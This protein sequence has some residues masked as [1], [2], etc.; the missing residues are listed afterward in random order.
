MKLLIGIRFYVKSL[1]HP[2]FLRLSLGFIC[3]FWMFLLLFF[4]SIGI[5][6]VHAQEVTWA[7]SAGGSFS[8]KGNDI[9]VDGYGNIYVVGNF[10]DTALF[11]AGTLYSVVLV[12]AGSSD[13]FLAKYAPDSTLL[14]AQ[15]AGGLGFDI[16]VGIAV[17]TSVNVVITGF[18]GG[19]AIFGQGQPGM[20][21]LTGAGSSDIFIA[22]YAGDGT[23][24]WAESAGGSED[25]YGEDIDIDLNNDIIVTGSFSNIA[26]FGSGQVGAISLSSKGYKNIF[27]AKY[28]SD[29]TLLWAIK[30]GGANF[31]YGYGVASDMDNHVFITG[32]FSAIA[33]FGGGQP[34]SVNLTC[35][36]TLDIFVAKYSSSGT[37]LWAE[38]EGGPDWDDGSAISVDPWGNVIVTGGFIGTTTFDGGQVP[39]VIFN[40][41]GY[42]DMFLAKYTSDGILIWVQ[43]GGGGGFDYGKGMGVDSLGNI[44]VTGN[45]SISARFGEGQAGDTTITG[46]DSMEVFLAMYNSNGMLLWAMGINGPDYEYGY[47]VSIGKANEFLITGNFQGTLTFASGQP[48]EIT[49]TSAGS[50]DV[51]IAKFAPG[52]SDIK[53][54]SIFTRNFILFQNY[55]NPFNPKTMIKYYLSKSVDIEIVLYNILGQKVKELCS[56]KQFS[57]PHTIELDGSELTSG[58]YYYTL[59][60]EYFTD[61]KKCLLLK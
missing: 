46:E 51:F 10:E 6:Y 41:Y 38:G 25:D 57:G 43:R 29:G 14:W 3:F 15:S 34:D 47:G 22:E 27:L 50:E 53:H 17:D 32:Q 19:T 36:G 31:D 11:G 48:G 12:S 2:I 5:L 8:D 33:T 35:S 54:N 1:D 4:C 58:I 37:F 49:L 13:I 60:S 16:G 7:Q 24:L 21:A 44:L 56:G 39:A 55:P 20:V 40:S 26:T 61:T 30:A 23:V 9:A 18:F 52:L 59:H 42:N 45:F 28:G